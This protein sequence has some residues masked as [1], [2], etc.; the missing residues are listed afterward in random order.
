MKTIK[1]VDVNGKRVL[2]RVGFDLPLAPNG[3]FEQGSDLRIKEGLPTLQ[4]LREHGARL[5]LLNHFG[6]PIGPD[7]KY[8]NRRVAEAL[9]SLLG[10]PVK[11]AAAAAGPEAEAA[12]RALKAGEVLMAENVR[13]DP[14]EKRNDPVF[15]KALAALG[16]LYVNDAFSADYNIDAS[17]VA[18][19]DFLPS[20]AGLLLEREVAMM[21]RVMQRPD[22]PLVVIIGGAKVD[23][24][25]AVVRRFLIEADHVILGGALANTIL[26]MQGIAVGKSI[27]DFKAMESVQDLDLTSAKLHMPVDAVV[28]SDPSG[29]GPTHVAPIGRMTDEE[30]IL[31]VGPETRQLFDR[32]INNAKMVVWNGPL[33]KVEASVFAAGTL[34]LVESIARSGAFS[35]TGGGD[36]MTFLSQHRLMDKISYISTGGGTMLEYLSGTQLPAIEKLR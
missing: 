29:K 28:S 31:D 35:I 19:T 21:D 8:S 27:I 26:H 36:S 16:D 34:A 7:L 15:A 24:K 25:I 33:G 18:I 11:T 22:R 1:D 14:G 17:L 32:I 3:D 6:R 9:S 30:M 20:Y 13:F 4:L 10:V 2:V 12:S 5:V 23:T